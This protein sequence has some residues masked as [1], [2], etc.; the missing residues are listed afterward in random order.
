MAE[1]D[2]LNVE[3]RDET[4]K[5][6]VRRLRAGGKIP[7]VVYGHG[8]ES[9]SLSV[10]RDEV[11]RIIDH[12]HRIVALQGGASGNAFIRDVQWDI[13][14]HSI[15]HI[16]FTHV[17]AGEMIETTIAIELRGE[18]PGTHTG[19]MVVQPIQTMDIKCPPRSMTDKIFVNINELELDQAIRVGQLHLP[20]GAE[21]LLD[22][23]TIVVQC[24]EKTE[25]PEYEEEI[26]AGATGAE[27]EVIGGKQDNDEDGG[28]R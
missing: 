10:P 25:G 20:E 11:K 7:A 9:V 21:A 8:A 23:D 16:D 1:I 27:P 17:E 28:D 22:E 3:V 6:K 18:A 24:V 12:G 14:G 13:Y 19:G 4:G 2:V 5:R 15:L 26:A